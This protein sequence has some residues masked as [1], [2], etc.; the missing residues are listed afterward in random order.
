MALC[1]SE[2]VSSILDGLQRSEI[3][4]Y[5]AGSVGV[6]LALSSGMILAVFQ[7]LGMVLCFM[8]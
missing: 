6:F 8:E 3:G 5:E 1:C 7:M 4:R 2:P